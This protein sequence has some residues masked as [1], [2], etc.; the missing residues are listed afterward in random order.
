[1]GN[2]ILS[3]PDETSTMY[4]YGSVRFSAS[5][6]VAFRRSR[7]KT[8]NPSM[9]SWNDTWCGCGSVKIT[10]CPCET[11][12]RL[13]G[14][15]CFSSCPVADPLPNCLHKSSNDRGHILCCYCKPISSYDGYWVNGIHCKG[16][17]GG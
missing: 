17:L 7:C 14:S 13:R 8:I 4:D 16:D 10:E 9:R 11:C 15:G 5:D 6:S 1:M 12:T 2:C 3:M